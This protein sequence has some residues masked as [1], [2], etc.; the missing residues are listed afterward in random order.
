MNTNTQ[1]EYE[2]TFVKEKL[3]IAEAIDC[4]K[5]DFPDVHAKVFWESIREKFNFTKP[6]EL[7]EKIYNEVIVHLDDWGLRLL[8]D[9][10]GPLKANELILDYRTGYIDYFNPT[11]IEYYRGLKE[12]EENKDGMPSDG[13]TYFPDSDKFQQEEIET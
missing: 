9:E 13:Y 10:V 5:M 6:S 1:K 4:L 3:T 12:F 8:S 11:K 2:N 7:D